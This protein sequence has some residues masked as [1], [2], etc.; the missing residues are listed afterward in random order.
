LPSFFQLSPVELSIDGRLNEKMIALIEEGDDSTDRSA[1]L[2]K[3]AISMVRHGFTDN[4]I[5]TV[6]TEKDTYLGAA[7]FEHAKTNDRTRAA[8]WIK[9]YTLDK[10]RSEFDVTNEFESRVGI[11]ENDEPELPPEEVKKQMKGITDENF[12]SQ[13]ERAD[14]GRP[15]H[16]LK[17]VVT[18]LAGVFGPKLFTQNEFSGFQLYGRDTP[19]N[20]KEGEE[21]KDSHIA[22]I[23]HWFATKWRFEPS[24]DKVNNAITIIAENNGFHPVRAYLDEL[25]WDGKPRLSTWLKRHLSAKAP[26]DY[27]EAVSRKVIIAMVARIY[28]PG[29]KFDQVLI[30]EG[31]QGIGKSRAV[32]ALA[33]DEWF[34]DA[35]VDLMNKDGVLSMRATWLMELG[36]LSG[37]RRSDV[38]ALKEFVS[39][40]VDRIRVPYGKRMENFPRQC[41]F[42]G[43]TNNAEYLRDTTGNR[44]F[45]PVSVGECRI[46]DLAKERDQLLAEAKWSYE[47]GEPL[48]IDDDRAL[49]Q[50]TS[51]Q[52]KRVEKDSWGEVIADFLASPPENFPIDKFTSVDL[53][54][55]V[56]L[57]D[58][59]KMGRAEQMR[60]ASCLRLLGYRNKP[61]RDENNVL[62]RFWHKD[63]I[64]VGF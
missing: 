50:A 7:A 2:F 58:S 34:S 63:E 6:L 12:K 45:W 15:K 55:E 46:D 47:L 17:N 57:L 9:R 8:L 49:A 3:A 43:T 35:P 13:I 42:I 29:K 33:G 19:W 48:W 59:V 40:R 20:A 44:R 36:E 24:P 61:G 32:R 18:I 25:A 60:V 37:M 31:T 1:A 64:D 54:A 11:E 23:I 21:I 62:K 38:D 14:G 52:E 53:F 30:L 27:L 39:R 4:E 10:A 56:Q 51:E 5:M 26:K 16:T 22:L 41:V 28:E